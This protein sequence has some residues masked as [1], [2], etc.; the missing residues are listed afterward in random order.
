MKFTAE[1]PQEAHEIIAKWVGSKPQEVADQMKR[2]KLLNIEAN[3]SIVFNASNPLNVV[4]S[5]DTAAPILSKAG[6]IKKVV[7]GKTLIDDSLI[8]AL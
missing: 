7:T 3:K 4:N 6:I 5:I 2:I 1:N 8:K